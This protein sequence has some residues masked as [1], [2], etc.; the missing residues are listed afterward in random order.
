LDLG[1]DK[2]VIVPEKKYLLAIAAKVALFRY[3]GGV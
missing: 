3:G 2:E 1:K